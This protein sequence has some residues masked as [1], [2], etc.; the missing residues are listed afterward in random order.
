MLREFIRAT[1]LE[2]VD[3]K[4]QCIGMISGQ[5]PQKAPSEE[6]YNNAANNQLLS[7]IKEMGFEHFPTF[8]YGETGYLIPNISKSQLM[9]LGKKYNQKAVIWGSKEPELNGLAPKWNWQYLESGKIR[10]QKTSHHPFV[11]PQF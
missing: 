9:D 1:L 6:E 10:A 3:Q 8:Y 2:F 7:D 11:C 4:M 5:N